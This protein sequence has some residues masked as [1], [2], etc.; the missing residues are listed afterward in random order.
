MSRSL[1]SRLCALAITVLSTI[2]M[3]GVSFEAEAQRR[4]GGG[5]F[6]R[7]SPN[8]MQNRQATPP[9]RA[10]QPSAAQPGATASR[11]AA[12]GAAG[13]QAARSGASRWF[14]P[15]AGIAAGLGLA[16]LLSHLGLGAAAAEFLAS[17]LLIAIVV[18]AALY[19]FRRL[20]HGGRQPALQGAAHGTTMHRQS[21]DP[22]TPSTTFSQGGGAAPAPSAGAAENP[23]EEGSW[24][25]P[26]GFDTQQFLENA[27]KHF[28]AL[29][30][31]WDKKD[32]SRMREYMTDELIDAIQEPLS[33]REAGGVTEVV[34]LT[35]ELL[36]VENITEGHLA[37][38]RFSGMLRDDSGPEAYRFEEVWN[39]LK[40]KQGGWLLAGIQQVPAEYAS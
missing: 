8:V 24:Y 21:H 10:S 23:T 38:V 27:K 2:A 34:L 15:I 17:L 31:A 35:A 14:G 5:N 25:I 37:S 18:F 1:S 4:L 33:K 32:L 20:R 29:Q 16:A 3:L 30:D 36:G 26:S 39:F 12:A 7:Q 11:S 28:I 13:A 22:H 6:G 40:P 19:L 9:A